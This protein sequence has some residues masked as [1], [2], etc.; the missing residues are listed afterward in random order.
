MYHKWTPFRLS[1]QSTDPSAV[2]RDR[3]AVRYTDPIREKANEFKN[4]GIAGDPAS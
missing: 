1:E 4:D 3:A 2:L